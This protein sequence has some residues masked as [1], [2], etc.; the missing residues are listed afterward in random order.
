[1]IYTLT[2]N[3]AIDYIVQMPELIAGSVNRAVHSD[4]Y[5]GGKGLNVSSMLSRLG[6]ESTAL[7]FIAGPT[8]YMIEH[9]LTDTAAKDAP[10]YPDLTRIDKGNSR[11]NVKI[12]S[13]EIN[14]EGPD[15]KETDLD[16][17]YGKIDDIADGDTLIISGSIPPGVPADVYGVICK[18]VRESGKNVRLIVDATGTSLTDTLAYKP[19]LIKPNHIE[20]GEI[21]GVKTD[22]VDEVISYGE[23]LRDMGAV[24]VLVS[25]GAMGAVLIDETGA[26]HVCEAPKGEVI[27]AVGSGDS[28]VAAF[29]AA[30]NRFGYNY[31]H[32][33]RFAVCAGSASAFVSGLAC[34]DD[35]KS[36]YD[37][38]TGH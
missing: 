16:R 7:G 33:L 28:M 27:S 9:M 21:F 23:K 3:T 12:G 20:L 38:I 2:L 25:M 24:N 32:T 26:V 6:L 1:M 19:Y 34:Y 17:L 11:I 18:R 36:L 8:G 15:I 5:P 14:G 29:I 22:T 30:K 37:G 31:D 4:I 10:I 35:I 13:T